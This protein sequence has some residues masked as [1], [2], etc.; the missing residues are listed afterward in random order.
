MDDLDRKILRNVGRQVLASTT[1]EMRD[2]AHR[3]EFAHKL[4]ETLEDGVCGA[5]CPCPCHGTGDTGSGA[6]SASQGGPG[7]CLAC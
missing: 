5:T 6:H 1:P 4:L 7:G 3:V 2:A